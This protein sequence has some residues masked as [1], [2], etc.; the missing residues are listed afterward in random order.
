MSACFLGEAFQLGIDSVQVTTSGS[1]VVN[2]YLQEDRLHVA[3]PNGL[4]S[5]VILR[6]PV[7]LESESADTV[8]CAT[9]RHSCGQTY[10]AL[11]DAVHD[12]SLEKLLVLDIADSA[13]SNFRNLKYMV[14]WMQAM[15]RS[16]RVMFSFV[17][18]DG[19]QYHLVASIAL[20]RAK[21]GSAL[22]SASVLM[23]VGVNKWRMLAAL[24][25]IVEEELVW[26]QGG[27]P[28]ADV[29]EF[30]LFVLRQ[31]LMRHLLDVDGTLNDADRQAR[32]R[33]RAD[34]EAHIER[35]LNILNYDWKVPKV[36]H[37]C[38]RLPTGQWCC[39]NRSLV[40]QKRVS[41][42]WTICG[43]LV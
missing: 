7:L 19:H 23:R 12:R 40:L 17:R 38:R 5:E 22:F 4:S 28:A 35:V 24:R 6:P 39:K 42:I 1:L 30:S 25:C 33:Q 13:S 9:T 20:G 8:F 32:E 27:Q 36:G 31:T 26:T 11:F 29:R 14:T 3:G 34:V 21:V 37:R 15:A 41:T 2:S 16:D 43:G 18:C 10:Q